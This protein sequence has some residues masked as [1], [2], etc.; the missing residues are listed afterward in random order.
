MQVLLCAAVRDRR[1]LGTAIAAKSPIRLT[2]IITSTSVNPKYLFRMGRFDLIAVVI[3]GSR[4]PLGLFR[5]NSQKYG[6][7]RRTYRIFSP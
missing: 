4:M 6:N 1:K 2:T 3:N 7:G 5:G